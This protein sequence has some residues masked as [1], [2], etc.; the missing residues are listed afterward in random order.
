MGRTKETEQRGFRERERELARESEE[1]ASEQRLRTK[2]TKR[3][4]QWRE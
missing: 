4:T 2:R 1:R 3:D